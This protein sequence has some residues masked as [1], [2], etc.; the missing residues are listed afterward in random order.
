[1]NIQQLLEKH[2]AR[3]IGEGNKTVIM[4][5]DNTF[6]ISKHRKDVSTNEVKKVLYSILNRG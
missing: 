1:M 6:T 4:V 3:L 5:N 2:K